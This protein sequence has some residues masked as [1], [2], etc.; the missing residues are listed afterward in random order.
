MK[1]FL[2]KCV[3][4]ISKILFRFLDE[5]VP[6]DSCLVIFA[7]KSGK[8]NNANANEPWK[9]LQQDQRFKSYLIDRAIND[10]CHANL[11]SLKGL[12]RILRAKYVFLTH[13][14]NDIIYAWYGS[15]KIITYIGHGVPLKAMMYTIQNQNDHNLF[16][17]KFEVPGY[18]YIISSS[19][20]DQ[21]TLMKC[22]NKT[23]S[24]V[25]VTGLPRN[26]LLI[27][28]NDFLKSRFPGFRKYILYAPTHREKDQ[29]KFFP[30]EDLNLKKL[31]EFLDSQNYLLVLR[32]HVNDKSLKADIHA[33]SNIVTL[34]FDILPEIEDALSGFDLLI[35]DYS[36]IYIDFLLTLKPLM[37]IPYDLEDYSQSRGLLYNYKDIAPGPF[38]YTQEEFTHSLNLLLNDETAYL[39]DRKRVKSFFHK[40]DEGFSK[41]MLDQ[42]LYG[43]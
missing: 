3:L 43:K 6:K 18:D 16:F 32:G 36:S 27:T 20:A 42:V 9:V 22:F 4:I 17:H 15:R 35:T 33:S 41:R 19:E 7:S 21:Q 38:V 30:F 13:G 5:L 11:F 29:A 40:Y 8:A 2:K 14:P 37:F 1:E 24:Q 25:L 39:E 26:D 23:Q 34:N 31:N 28:G 12:W 10:S